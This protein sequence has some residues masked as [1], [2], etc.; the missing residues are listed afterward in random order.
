MMANNK[1]KKSEG[2]AV[3]YDVHLTDSQLE[4]YNKIMDNEI[5]FVHGPAGT[6]KTWT[7]SYAAL[8]LLMSNEVE[9]IVLVKPIEESGEKLGFLPGTVSEK[10]AP[11][12]ESFFH[13]MGKMMDPFVVGSLS[14]EGKI[15]QKPLAYMRG[16]TFDDSIIIADEC[17]TGDSRVATGFIKNSQKITFKRAADIVNGDMVLSVN[18]EGQQEL[19]QVLSVFTDTKKVIR[20]KLAN[21]ADICVT[22]NHPIA[23]YGDE[24][25][26]GYKPAGQ[27]TERDLVIK[28]VQPGLQNAKPVKSGLDVMLGFILGDGSLIRSKQEIPAYR[29]VKNHGMQQYDYC[30]YCRNLTGGAWRKASSGYTGKPICGFASKNM[31]LPA[32]FIESCYDKN[33]KRLTSDITHYFT[34]RTI[35]A[36][37]M[38][39]G[40]LNQTGQFI[41]CTHGFDRES[42]NILHS[43]L[44]DK[45]GLDCYVSVQKNRNGKGAE[46]YPVLT[47]R[48]GSVDRLCSLVSGMIHPDHAYKTKSYSDFAPDS[49]SITF[50][51]EVA[52]VPVITLEEEL[53]EAPVYNF[54]VEGN[55]NYVVEKILV[56]NC[57]NMDFR[58]LM[59][60]LTRMGKNTKVVIAGDVSQYDIKENLVALPKFIEMV[61][62][63]NGVVT[64]EFGNADIVRNPILIEIAERYERWK[65][66]NL[67]TKSKF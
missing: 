13:N 55:N 66:E 65:H 52:A 40:Y 47:V 27:L 20:V 2:G 38:D 61:A 8:K 19:R 67:V 7:A 53:E 50:Y 26:I 35:A 3:F 56:H 15:L 44:Q 49:L 9:R 59:L 24:G 58:Q 37:M 29:L 16:A 51:E 45:F 23:I 32:R 54:E 57:Q 21:A 12:F 25:H 34:E 22:E 14:L 18:D 46:D 17:V 43:I 64:H 42:V 10:I 1:K 28:I 31:V 5:T 60:L 62:G 4:L 11:F 33:R 36:W 30:D 39:D 63:V 48:N 6:S 41:F